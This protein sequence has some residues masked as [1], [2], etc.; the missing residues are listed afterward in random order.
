MPGVKVCFY[1]IKEAYES[2]KYPLET[3]DE[4]S[5]T[6]KPMQLSNTYK[7]KLCI[8]CQFV[9]YSDYKSMLDGT[10]RQSKLSNE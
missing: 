5:V 4:C 1:C 10:P 2:M 3:C 9:R 6:F 7:L 8:K